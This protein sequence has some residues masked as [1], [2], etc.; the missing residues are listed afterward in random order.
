M[1]RFGLALLVLLAALVIASLFVPKVAVVVVEGN[2]HHDAAAVQRL[3]NV[4]AGDPFLWVT[5]TR[6][7]ALGE[8]PW[9]LNA[10]VVR[11]WPDRVTIGIRERTPALTDGATT[12]ADD[13]TVLSGATP[14]ETTGLPRLEGWGPGRV[15]EALV[16]LRLLRP[17][18]VLV[19]SYSPEGFDILMDGTRLF[20]PSA[21]AL[22]EHWAAFVSHRGGRMAVYPWG[23]SKAHE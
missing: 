6:V 7:R 11:Q 14:A 17:F 5:T 10:V 3:A 18:G 15:E 16:L 19:I 9:V 1:R 21:E 4:A 23:V 20:T 22:R 8:D 12:W 13:G 2:V